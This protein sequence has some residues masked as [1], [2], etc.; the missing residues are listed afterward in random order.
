MSKPVTH[1]FVIT[2]GSAK[3]LSQGYE[4]AKLM[5]KR[6]GMLPGNGLIPRGCRSLVIRFLKKNEPH[7]LS[8][9]EQFHPRDKQARVELTVT[10]LR[11]PRRVVVGAKGAISSENGN[12][13]RYW[14]NDPRR[15]RRVA[16]APDDPSPEDLRIAHLADWGLRAKKI[17]K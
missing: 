8:H 5:V 7:E 17:F 12:T 13:D 16:L 1:S 3:E 2:G 9:Y 4:D 11:T 15:A 14:V 10:T 6:N